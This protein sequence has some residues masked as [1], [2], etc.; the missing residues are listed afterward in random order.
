MI[1]DIIE[2]PGCMAGSCTNNLLI[3]NDLN[4]NHYLKIFLFFKAA[5]QKSVTMVLSLSGI[6]LGK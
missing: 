6:D 5:N 3:P 2:E 4:K 1:I